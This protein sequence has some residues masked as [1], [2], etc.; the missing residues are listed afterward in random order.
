MPTLDDA[1]SA[2]ERYFGFS[3][4]REGQADVIEALIEGKDVIVVMPTGSG[5]SLCYQLP[6]L[7]F[8]G[9]TLVV[10]PLIALM[11]DQVDAL[12]A[13]EIPATFINSSISFDEQMS[14]LRAMQRGE[15]RLVYIA[16]ERF[17]NARF[18]EYLKPVKVSLF[19]VDEAHCISQWGHDFRPDYLRLRE[20][21]ESLAGAAVRPRII[22]LTA[23]ATPQVRSDIA[24]QLGLK[25]PADFIAGFDRHNLIL[26]VD[27]CKKDDDR[28]AR[29][30]QIIKSANGTGIIYCSTRKAVEGLTR[31]L[32]R[33]GLTIG[34]YHAGMDDAKRARIQDRFM[35][36][37]LNAIVA[38]N[39]FGMGVDK[40]DL[41]FVTHY[42]M[43]GSIEA[44]Y[45]E[46]GRAGRDGLP[47]LCTL[48]FNYIDTRTHDF[49][50]EGGY[51]PRYLIEQIYAYLLGQQSET[52][53]LSARQICERLGIKNE[54]AVNSALIYL[55]KAGHIQRGQ[56]LGRDQGIGMID[57]A[58]VNEL[59]VDW[60]EIA[61]RQ[62]AERRKLREMVRYAY[63]EQCLR[64][65][66]LRY[67]GD[68]KQVA[69]CR[70][71]N[72]Q[73]RL[74]WGEVARVE[75][76]Q[77]AE[78]VI[79]LS[80]PIGP[81]ALTDEEHLTARKI[82]SCVAR[83]D[84]RF[85]KGT[86]AGVLRGS[87][88]KNILAN[89]L[90]QLSTYGLLST[91]SQ[92]ELTQF[93]N[94]LIVAGCVN[95]TSGQTSAQSGVPYPVVGLT[96]LGRE[97]MHD[98]QRVE[99]DLE[100]VEADISDEE[101]EITPKPGDTH[102]QTYKLYLEGLGVEQIAARRNLRP[103]TVEEH[104]EK[105]INDGRKIDIDDLVDSADR[106]LIEDAAQKLGVERLKPIKEALPEHIGYGAIKLVVIALRRRQKSGSSTWNLGK[107]KP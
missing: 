42:N 48:L 66:I 36:G 38:T 50:I 104:F 32:Q 8:E 74:K 34:M 49:F 95:Q 101:I 102:E 37:E 90:D 11:K 93:I 70:C 71:S 73:P 64:Q 47:S 45:Q 17:R 25:D 19:A 31:N 85:G 72:C 35:A 103:S 23:T 28:V 10:S 16:P 22:A 7:L 97:V 63:H 27:P 75:S 55:E 44:Y 89:G 79:A 61:R 86:V 81:R 46:V 58:A 91:Y 26:R 82:L 84:G 56:D 80:Q 6:A 57:R 94:A 33:S 105:L 96:P 65:F 68:R 9:T 87:K 60:G 43:P 1:K 30:Y 107:A 59:K 15:H 5:K 14:R 20:A 77:A 4:F 62:V 52:V 29:A 83:L 18:V 99:L 100:A 88:A 54:I 40:A 53:Y 12:N 41:R 67:F 51:P 13:R 2:L 24:A 69:N 78:T 21:A 106:A 39:A 98:R 76:K 92:D 3:R